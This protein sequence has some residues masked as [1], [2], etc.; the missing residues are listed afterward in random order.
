[1]LYVNT[2]QAPNLRSEKH[3][4]RPFGRYGLLVGIIFCT[5]CCSRCASLSST[6]RASVAC[7]FRF[8]VKIALDSSQ[9]ALS[10][11]VIKTTAEHLKR[12]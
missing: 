7:K 4:L 11:Q 5:G 8:T 2:L 3:F 9:T 6:T 1:M 10:L 12:I